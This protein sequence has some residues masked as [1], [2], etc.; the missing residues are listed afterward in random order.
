MSILAT[1]AL[2]VTD[3]FS[4]YDSASRRVLDVASGRS[5]QDLGQALSDQ[6]TAKAQVRAALGVVKI[7][8]DM[9]KALL[10][11]GQQK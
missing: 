8:D 6:V 10:Q 9:F 2:A 4:R 11:I 1:P 7:G 5:N 3:A